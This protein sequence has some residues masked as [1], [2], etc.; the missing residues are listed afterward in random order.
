MR[1][2]VTGQPRLAVF[3]RTRANVGATMRATVEPC[4]R[5]GGDTRSGF[6]TASAQSADTPALA[7]VGANAASAAAAA[8]G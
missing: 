5:E 1:S 2:V 6:A 3:G 7:L 8:T 4:A